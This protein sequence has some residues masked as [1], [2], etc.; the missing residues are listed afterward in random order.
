MSIDDFKRMFRIPIFILSS[1][2]VYAGA[3]NLGFS[4][5]FFAFPFIIIIICFA[6]KYR[7][8][9]LITTMGVVAFTGAL[10][11][12]KHNDSSIFYPANGKTVEAQETLCVISYNDRYKHVRPTQAD[13]ETC[14]NNPVLGSSFKVEGEL[15]AGS[16]Y[17]ITETKVSSPDFSETYD[18]VIE[19]EY[20]SLNVS[21]GYDSSSGFI[22]SESGKPVSESDLRR[23]VFYYPSLLMNYPILPIILSSFVADL[24]S[25]T[26]IFP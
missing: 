3:V 24:K 8:A 18:F 4:G 9:Y 17:E 12:L 2:M 25:F 13:N 11:G 20:G 26:M 7:G 16:V 22:L 19:T 15:R 21:P 23:A 6:A 1:F 14:E 10:Y 5:V